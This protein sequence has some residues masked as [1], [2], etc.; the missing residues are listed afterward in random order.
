MKTDEMCVELDNDLETAISNTAAYARRLVESEQSTLHLAERLNSEMPPRFEDL[1]RCFVANL[2]SRLGDIGEAFVRNLDAKF[3]IKYYDAEV[4]KA[5]T[6]GIIYSSWPKWHPDLTRKI[7]ITT[8]GCAVVTAIGAGLAIGKTL[9]I[10]PFRLPML[11]GSPA[12]TV[13]SCL[14]L[15]FVASAVAARPETLPFV[16]DHERNQAQSRVDAHL[17]TLRKELA[18]AA[19]HAAECLLAELEKL[20]TSS[21]PLSLS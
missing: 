11:L 15:T 3:R 10:L 17:A 12:A 14:A 18:Q 8:G 20:K 16:L 9:G 2:E 13:L 5:V 6:R 1:H 7:Q 19:R 4:E 21:E